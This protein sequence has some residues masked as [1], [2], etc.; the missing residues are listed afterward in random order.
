MKNYVLPIALTF[1]FS[2]D[3]GEKK[4]ETNTKKIEVSKHIGLIEYDP[5]VDTL[6][7]DVCDENLV[8]PYFHHKDLSFKGEKP[9]M[10]NKYKMLFE[11]TGKPGSG[12]ITIRFIVNCNGET[13]RFRVIQMDKNYH[14]KSFS[15]KLVSQ[16][17]E[18]TKSLQGWDVLYEDGRSYDYVRY[19]TFKIHEG[20]IMDIMP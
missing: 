6:S 3:P 10:V 18:V 1:L 5:L 17:L 8:Y 12:Y 7:F 20:K 13:G 19:V 4:I 9:A 14:L 2:C 15:K 11:P 16:L